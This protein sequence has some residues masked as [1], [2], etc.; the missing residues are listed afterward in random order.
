MTLARAVAPDVSPSMH[1]N[2]DTS[3][4][5]VNVGGS[6]F[7]KPSSICEIRGRNL[8]DPSTFVGFLL[9][10]KQIVWPM[11]VR[12]PLTVKAWTCLP[13][14]NTP[15]WT[16]PAKV[17]SS[18]CGST[19]IDLVKQHHQYPQLTSRFMVNAATCPVQKPSSAIRIPP[20]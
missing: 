7:L 12:Y 8:S 10:A 14:S 9:V 1:K 3:T 19:P 4:N 11:D 17:I 2:S 6:S 13:Q 5:F 16:R 18:K 20:S 15:A